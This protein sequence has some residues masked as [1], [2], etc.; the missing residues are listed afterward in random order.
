MLAVVILPLLG[1]LCSP[2]CVILHG[3]QLGVVVDGLLGQLYGLLD[4]A[5]GGRLGL[6]HYWQLHGPGQLDSC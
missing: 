6:L 4:M 3:G 2:L 5:T 1:E